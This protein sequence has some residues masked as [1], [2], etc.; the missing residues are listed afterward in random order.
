VLTSASQEPVSVTSTGTVSV[1]ESASAPDYAIFVEGGGA[2]TVLNDG[3]LSGFQGIVFTA[4]GTVVNEG[5]IRG[6]NYGVKIYGVAGAMSTVTNFGTIRGPG[7]PGLLGTGVIIVGG[8]IVENGS[9]KT[10]NGVITGAQYGVELIGKDLVNYYG[11]DGVTSYGTIESTSNSGVAVELQLQSLDSGE[12]INGSASLKSALIRGATGVYISASPGTGWTITNFGTIIGFGADGKGVSINA[13]YGTLTNGTP[14][15]TGA[16]IEGAYDGVDGDGESITITN[17]GTIIASKGYSLIMYTGVL[18]NG[19]SGDTGSLIEGVDVGAFTYGYAINYGTI[20]ATGQNSTGLIA[21]SI[22]NVGATSLIEGAGSGLFV[23]DELINDGTIAASGADGIGV[24]LR[25][26]GTICN[27]GTISGAKDAIS[28]PGQLV[29]TVEPGAVFDGSVT[30]N[31]TGQLILAG[32]AAGSL[33]LS[34]FF[35]SVDPETNGFEAITF[36]VCSTWVLEGQ[37]EDFDNLL[38]GETITGFSLA[39]TIVLDGY[40]ANSDVFVSGTGL[41][42]GDGD[43][44]DIPE[45]LDIAGNYSTSEFDITTDGTNTTITLLGR[46]TACFA[47]GTRILTGHGTLVRVEDL[48]EG[49]EVETLGGEAARIVWIGRRSIAPRRHPRPDAVQPILIAAG[50]LG[51]GLPWRDLVLSPDHALYLD[52]HLIPAKVLTNGSNIRQLNRD[53]VTYYHIELPKHAVLFAEGAPAE[54]YLE[55]GNRG[56]FENGGGSLTLH[57]DFAQGLRDRCG[58]APFAESGKAVEIVRQKILNDAGIETTRAPQLQLRCEN[59]Q[60]IIASRSAIPGEI[61][62][63]PRDRRRLGVKICALT[64]GGQRIPL[65]HP[66]L[67]DGWH[68]MEADGRW[69]NGNA[70]I[71]PGLVGAANSIRIT[72]AATLPYPVPRRQSKVPGLCSSSGRANFD[73]RRVR[74]GLA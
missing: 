35:Q 38:H 69:T 18:T 41:I 11:F 44:Y 55:T 46:T 27:A 62:A 61:F 68:E 37:T 22:S 48:H 45:T 43:I 47:A 40:V 65:D 60:A 16:L 24:E 8:G 42:L 19:A 70:I 56:A 6:S 32:T 72:I 30:D 51:C 49:D 39:D 2:G 66:A 67:T 74:I 9:S 7:A 1:S 26:N 59:G 71:P 23:Y 15:D 5:S 50:A 14:T 52:G 29:L 12:V 57:P 36:A 63:D 4:G 20:V 13:G 54:S 31:G 17:Y 64:I 21:V 34:G 33:D 58:C 3:V 10:G 25:A 73:L 28:A 53:N